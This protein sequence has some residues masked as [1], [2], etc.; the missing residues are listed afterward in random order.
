MGVEPLGFEKLQTQG[1][2]KKRRQKR[3]R[4]KEETKK[5]IKSLLLT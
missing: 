5:Y 3:N 2:T 1:I 4:E